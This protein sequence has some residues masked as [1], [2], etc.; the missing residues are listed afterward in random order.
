MLELRMTAL[1]ALCVA[2]PA[3]KVA[4]VAALPIAYGHVDTARE[5]TEPQGVPGRPERPRLVRPAAVAQRSVA[6][7]QGRAALLH[8]LAH[9][10]FNAI[11]LALDITWRFVGLP[12][13]FYREWAHV[14]A[15]EA[16]HFSLLQSRLLELGVRYG[17]FPAHDGLWEMAART[18][19]DLCA[20]LALV[21]RT[22]E[23]RGL[24]A[25]PAVR[26]KFASAGD[27]KSAQIIDIILAD[28][29]GHVA[30]GNRWF[31]FVCRRL[32]IDPLEAQNAAAARHRA[33]ILRGPFNLDARRAA[34]FTDEELQALSAIDKTI[35][36]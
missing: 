17:D 18:R 15:E 19:T 6:T 14:A 35:A 10:E 22:L 5:F 23:A 26:A 33:P 16:H 36:P 32:D 28:E 25:S 13:D 4:A 29:I 3:A 24:D 31:K 11:N 20:R 7:E 2:D 12:E 9:I 34:G 30:T 1:A 21:P 8:A 27:A